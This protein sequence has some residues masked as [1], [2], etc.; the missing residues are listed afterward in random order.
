VWNSDL[1]APLQRILADAAPSIA[2]PG[3]QKPAA[4]RP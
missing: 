2:R 4:I 3:Q 1:P